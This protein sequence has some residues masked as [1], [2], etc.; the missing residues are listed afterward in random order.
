MPDKNTM[1]N[2]STIYFAEKKISTI[3]AELEAENGA[4]VEKIDIVNVEITGISDDREQLSR[5]VEIKM[6]RIPGSHWI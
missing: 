3:L 6:K 2:T 1:N 4:L 5:R